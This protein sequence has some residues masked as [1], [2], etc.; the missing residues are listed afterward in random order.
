KLCL[1]GL[2]M[3]RTGG[4]VWLAIKLAVAI[5]GDGAILGVDDGEVNRPFLRL[6]KSREGTSALEEVAAGEPVPRL[7]L[8]EDNGVE[9]AAVERLQ[10][11]R[12][13]AALVEICQRHAGH[14]RPR[15][16]RPGQR[17]RGGVASFAGEQ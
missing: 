9:D 14:Q 4:A 7:L 1:A 11:D 17:R 12:R 5:S 10:A 3:H 8:A 6:G 2:E 15:L 16:D 13:P